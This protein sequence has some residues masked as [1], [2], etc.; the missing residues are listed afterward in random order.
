MKKKLYF[1]AIF[2][3]VISSI[4]LYAQTASINNVFLQTGAHIGNQYGLL[5]KIDF[6]VTGLKEIPSRVKIVLKNNQGIDIFSTVQGFTP[7]YSSCRYAEYVLFIPYD[8]IYE[9]CHNI[10]GNFTSVII[11]Q[12]KKGYITYQTLAYKNYSPDIFLYVAEC[13]SCLNHKGVCYYC[14]GKGKILISY[15]MPATHCPHCWGNGK[16]HNCNGKTYEVSC[17][18]T[19]EQPIVPPVGRGNFNNHQQYN[20]RQPYDDRKIQCPTCNGTGRCSICNGRGEKQYN[21]I[22]YDCEMCHGTGHCYGKCA[23]RGYFY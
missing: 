16:C 9:R 10:T 6:T 14:R 8:C 2:L 11:I 5:Y 4:S 15:L 17:W 18:K 21:G 7:I 20:D 12:E 19:T 3:I 13:V 23:G 22:Y 1:I